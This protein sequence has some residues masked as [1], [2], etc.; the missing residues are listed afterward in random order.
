[1][2]GWGFSPSC[3]CPPVSSPRRCHHASQLVPPF[4]FAPRHARWPFGRNAAPPPS[5]QPPPPAAFKSFCIDG[6]QSVAPGTNSFAEVRPL[7]AS[8]LLGATR[9]GLL[10]DFWR[11]YGPADAAGF[12]DKTDSAAFQL[13]VWEIINDGLPVGTRLASDLATGQFSV[14][15]AGR[16]MPAALRAAQWLAGFDTTAPG[17]TAVALHALQD[18]IRQDQVVCVPTIDLDVDSD[19]TATVA[20]SS[21]E[22]AIEQVADKPGVIVPVGGD[23]AKMIVDVPAG[24]TA[25]LAF[26]AGA[27]GRVKV[28]SS[29][30]TVVLEQGRLSTPI[31]GGGSPQ[32]FWIEAFAP[33]ASM[34]DIAFTLTA[35]GTGTASSDKILAT[36][37]AVDLTID[38]LAL[39]I[40]DGSGAVIWRNSDFTR[41]IQA[42]DPRQTEPGVTRYLPDYTTVTAIDPAFESQFTKA[43]ATITAGMAAAYEFR[44]AIGDP[45]PVALWTKTQW[46]GFV[47]AADGWWRIPTD[48][49]VRPKAIKDTTLDFWIEGLQSTG[50][51]AGSIAFTA[52][53]TA[54]PTAA[55]PTDVANFTVLDAGLGVD[56]NRDGTIDFADSFDRQLTFWLNDDRETTEYVDPAAWFN[57]AKF[58][59]DNASSDGTVDSADRV[60]RL[61]RD[62]EDLAALRLLIDPVLPAGPFIRSSDRRDTPRS[63]RPLVR[64]DL[65]LDKASVARL[66][67]FRAAGERPDS[68]VRDATTAELQVSDVQFNTFRFAKEDPVSHSSVIGDLTLDSDF[69]LESRSLRPD[70]LFEAFGQP[71]KTTLTFTVTVTYPQPAGSGGGPRTTARSHAL[72]LDLRSIEDFYT[73]MRVPYRQGVIDDRFKEF[74]PGTTALPHFPDAQPLFT[75]RTAAMPFLSGTDTVV[76]VH[77]W[78]MTDGTQTTGPS[79]DWKKAFAET[80]FKRLYWQGFR[81]NFTAFDWPTFADTEGPLQD[82]DPRILDRWYPGALIEN[83]YRN[84]TYNASEYQAWRSGQSLMNY[85]ASIRSTSGSTHVLAHSMGNVVAAESL[86]QWTAAGNGQALVSNYV[87]MQGALS[88]GAYGD[89]ATDATDDAGLDYYRYWPAGW[90]GGESRNYMQGTDQA[91]G[92]WINMFNEVDRAT[93]SELAWVGNNRIKPLAGSIWRDVAPGISLPDAR[94]FAYRITLGGKLLRSY[95]TPTGHWLYDGETDMTPG[96]SV[97]PQHMPGPAAY[98]ALAF[99]SKASAKPIGTKVVDFFVRANGTNIDIR[100]LGLP[101]DYEDEWPGHSFQFHFDAAT[102]SQFWKRVVDETRMDTVSTPRNP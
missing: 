15:A 87:A 83:A 5:P 10:A 69:N 58:E 68:H 30:G 84:M 72:S 7:A 9:A 26:D 53:H 91:A 79:S 25:T 92:R 2:H 89:N 98:E 71:A 65:R 38:D 33:S 21:F 16:T 90:N 6:L 59:T 60:L 97:G 32:P 40:E 14:A 44:F 73:R 11:Q 99:M 62:L 54:I 101:D 80:A 23:R 49:N 77:G 81:G 45:A 93:S 22:E 3:R 75:G 63:D 48:R 61:T 85:L 24:R 57:S 34:A 27:A 39:D 52:L 37:V 41:H 55:R 94:R 18:P 86:R 1:V 51:A 43:R 70:F 19:N 78:N 28:F 76:L 35:T 29:A 64:Y 46:D 56:G 96:L 8:S 50:Y 66:R 47:A 100:S 13:A 82:Q 36:A 95:A 42:P 88:A 4:P 12:A 20:R 31:V 102:T 17:K 67:V 74:I